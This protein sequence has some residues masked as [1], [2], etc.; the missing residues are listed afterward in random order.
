MQIPSKKFLTAG[1]VAGAVALGGL[2]LAAAQ[3]GPRTSANHSS[4]E[5]HHGVM[6]GSVTPGA[7][8]GMGSLPGMGGHD[9][10]HRGMGMQG[11]PHDDGALAS[12]HE[13][14]ES[15][16]SQALGVETLDQVHEE[17]MSG[18]TLEEVAQEHGTTLQA[19]QDAVT[20]AVQ[21]LLGQAVQDGII[22]AAQE[23]QM[24]SVLVS[25]MDPHDAGMGMGAMPGANDGPQAQ[26]M[27]RGSQVMPFDLSRTTHAFTDLPDGGREAIMVNDPI[28]TDQ[29]AL[30]RSHLQT[31]A[32]KFSTGDFADPAQIHGSNMP[33]LAQVQAGFANITFSYEELSNGA[34]IT[35]SS[36]DPTLVLALHTWFAAQRSDHSAHQMK[37]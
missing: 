27:S 21:P 29:I 17:L 15:A 14:A 35:Y 9:M 37:P 33:G 31:E 23:Q 22:T 12:I 28:D 19:V 34:A 32:Q 24:L 5:V 2:G 18:K 4:M 25:G 10:D 7:M 11:M 16:L 26:V 30:I 6:H 20:A 13:A 36:S 3:T 1:V 8:G